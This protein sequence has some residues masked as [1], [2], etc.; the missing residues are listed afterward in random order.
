MTDAI[1]WAEHPLVPAI[2]QHP[3]TQQVLMLGFM[4]AEAFRLTRETGRVHFFSRSRDTLWRKG[5]TSGNEL[6]VDEIRV[7]CERNSLLVLATPLGPTCHEGYSTCFFRRIE[8]DGSLAIVLDRI[9]DPA[10][11][12]GAAESLDTR[13]RRWYQAYEL[14]RD[15]DPTAVSGTARR[16]RDAAFPL[17]DRLADELRELAGVLDGTHSHGK[18][19]DDIV[20]EGSQCLYWCALIAIRHGVSVDGVRPDRALVIGAEHLSEGIAA[21]V[22]RVEAHSWVDRGEL[23]DIA[24]RC[25]ATMALVAQACAAAGIEPAALI[26]KDLAD[27]RTK[28]YLASLFPPA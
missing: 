13:V 2:V 16:L 18:R 28:P 19:A 23:G 21:S 15:T 8:A 27:L 4:N 10:H 14:L 5:E 24:A 25:H 6:V 20:L 11:I 7:N 1:R 3:E 12:Y 26:D 17:A 9:E 22:L